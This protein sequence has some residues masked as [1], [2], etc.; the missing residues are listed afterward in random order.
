M[1]QN[2]NLNSVI[3]LTL[4]I[5]KLKLKVWYQKNFSAV[6]YYINRDLNHPVIQLFQ[7]Y[8][9]LVYGLFQYYNEHLRR[10][11]F[12]VCTFK[13]VLYIALCLDA[14]RKTS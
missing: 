14:W 9:M 4:A 2:A 1:V 13:A 10:N 8:L 5:K 7:I 3:A 12:T 6:I 11:Y